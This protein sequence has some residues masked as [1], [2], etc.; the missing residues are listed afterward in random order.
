MDNESVRA[1]RLSDLVPADDNEIEAT[2]AWVRELERAWSALVDAI[3]VCTDIEFLSESRPLVLHRLAV[4][5]RG[6]IAVLQRLDSLPG[7]A[8]EVRRD[9]SQAV[10][11]MLRACSQI[12]AKAT[13]GHAPDE[14]HLDHLVG[15]N[16][17]LKQEL[18]GLQRL[19]SARI[20]AR[21]K[22][23]AKANTQSQPKSEPGGENASTP[24]REQLSLAA[25]VTAFMAERAQLVGRLPTLAEIYAAFPEDEL[26]S[27]ASFYRRN[28][29]YVIARKS[30]RAML[31]HDA[32]PRGHR[33]SREGSPDGIDAAVD[34]PHH[35]EDE[36]S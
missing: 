27:K 26:G 9:V 30:L 11:E 4:G 15:A 12:E 33:N 10:G 24:I 22:D 1:G 21:K 6:M 19:Y 20:A 18:R 16:R 3:E 29:W 23:R 17:V 34:P 32:P 28:D 25:R 2:F 31:P 7:L 5:A 14:D 35:Y 36:A 8:P 13:A